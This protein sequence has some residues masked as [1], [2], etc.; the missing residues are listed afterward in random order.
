MP[1]YVET[2]FSFFSLLYQLQ[3][4]HLLNSV[5]SLSSLSKQTTYICINVS[6]GGTLTLL[7]DSTLTC[8][9]DPVFKKCLRK[10]MLIGSV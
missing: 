2:Q 5:Y 4:F 6:G 7:L 8:V 1:E 9:S 10:G 3:I